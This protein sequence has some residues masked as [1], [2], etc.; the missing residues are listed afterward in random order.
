MASA[1]SWCLIN[2]FFHRARPQPGLRDANGLRVVV[3]RRRCGGP[4]VWDG[5]RGRGGKI[6]AEIVP[7]TLHFGKRIASSRANG[8]QRRES[9]GNTPAGGGWG[10]D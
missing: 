3:R 1:A 10:S 9:N 7:F 8:R 6:D 5:S 4:G 2:I